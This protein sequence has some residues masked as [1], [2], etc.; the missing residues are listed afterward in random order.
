[1]PTHIG[2]ITIETEPLTTLFLLLGRRK[3]TE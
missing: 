2:L 3:P 1:V